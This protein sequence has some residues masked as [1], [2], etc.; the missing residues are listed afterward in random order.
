MFLS[1]S[2]A[3]FVIF[4]VSCH[5]IS[6]FCIYSF[7]SVTFLGHSVRLF[8]WRSTLSPHA[9]FPAL[10]VFPHSLC[11]WFVTIYLDLARPVTAAHFVPD[12][13]VSL[14]W[15][16]IVAACLCSPRVCVCVLPF[17]AILQVG[18]IITSYQVGQDVVVAL[19][20]LSLFDN[21]KDKRGEAESEMRAT[22][23][24]GTCLCVRENEARVMTVSQQYTRDRQYSVKHLTLRRTDRK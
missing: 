10:L 24:E 17:S 14:N 21:L 7:V 12:L 4:L 16:L 2:F 8:P 22:Q 23:T 13:Q 11:F 15:L 5:H 3:W 18:D 1:V 19:C 6:P 9:F 20:I